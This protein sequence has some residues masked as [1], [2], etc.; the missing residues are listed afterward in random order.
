[1][2]KLGIWLFSVLASFSM[3]FVFMFIAFHA[4]AYKY[5]VNLASSPGEDDLGAGFIMMFYAPA[6]FLSALV[7]SVLLI[8]F[9]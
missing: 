2:L 1:M 3:G 5:G 9:F 8:K 4:V 6:I 7:L